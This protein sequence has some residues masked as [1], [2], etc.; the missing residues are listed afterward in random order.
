MKLNLI[1]MIQESLTNTIKHAKATIVA[2]SMIQ[3][4]DTLTI[5]IKDNGVGFDTNKLSSAGHGVRNIKK[6][7]SDIG[8]TLDIESEPTKGT[9]ITISIVLKPE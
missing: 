4:G 5:K 6:R 2:F 1:R 8:A 3:K 9:T 7:C